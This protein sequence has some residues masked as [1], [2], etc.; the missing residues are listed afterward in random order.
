L[1]CAGILAL[2][3]VFSL[4]EN[5]NQSQF[6]VSINLYFLNLLLRLGMQYALI[7]NIKSLPEK[8]KTGICIGCGQ[9]VISKSGNIKIHH[10]SHKVK[11]D[12]DTWS[13]PETA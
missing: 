7:N 5:Q 12:C 9:E 8:G 6:I 4:L 2:L 3:S 1:V 13:E 11:E 10:W